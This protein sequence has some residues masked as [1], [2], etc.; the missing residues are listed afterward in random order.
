VMRGE[1]EE[2]RAAQNTAVGA[3]KV[4]AIK[5]LRAA[6]KRVSKPITGPDW[7]GAWPHL[8]TP[9][10]PSGCSCCGP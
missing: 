10:R 2:H 8:R 3:A 9:Q 7:L 5:E 1:G 6:F 4:G